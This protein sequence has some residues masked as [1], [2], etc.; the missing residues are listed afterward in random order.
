[1]IIPQPFRLLLAVFCLWGMCPIPSFAADLDPEKILQEIEGLKQKIQ[2][3]QEMIGKLESMLQEQMKE[4]SKESSPPAAKPVTL[5]NKALDGL[6]ITGDLR[7]RYELRDL[8]PPDEPS[9]KQD[10]IRHRFRIG[11]IWKNKAENWEIG[12]GLATGGYDPT[13]SNQTWGE[14]SAFS[15]GDIRLDY[16]YAKHGMGDF[17]ATLGQQK[18]PWHGSWVFWDSDVRPTGLTVQYEGETGLFATLGGYGVRFYK[19]GNGGNTSMM[20]AGQAGYRTQFGDLEI[21]AAAGYHHYDGEFSN[22]EAPNPEYDFQVGDIFA[23]ASFPV[24]FLK[25]SPYFQIWKNFGADGEIGEG[26][27]GGTLVPGD[28]DLGWI[29]GM[30]A[31]FSRVKLGYSYSVIEADSIYRRLIDQDFGTGLSNTDVKG[32]RVSAFYDIT[33]NW[34]AGITASFFEAYR[35]I[36]QPDVI[37]YQFDINYRF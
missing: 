34:D 28:E 25:L 29:A 27:Q 18:I 19:D 37:L 14:D 17:S 15:R 36:Q 4:K 22:W 6:D 13:S 12:A 23:S 2:A 30:N 1:M 7:L 24:G 10:R 21:L 9:E 35:R 20:G 8:D 11:G 3:Q 5:K 31:G 32:H 26:Q 16:A 33:R